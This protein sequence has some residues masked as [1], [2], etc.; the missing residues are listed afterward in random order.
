ML[1]SNLSKLMEFYACFVEILYLLVGDYF[2]LYLC[3]DL[4]GLIW[5]SFLVIGDLSVSRLW[6]LC[7]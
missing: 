6:C 7:F 1:V 2:E 3:K 5:E 4:G